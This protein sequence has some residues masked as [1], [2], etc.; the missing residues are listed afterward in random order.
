MSTKTTLH[1]ELEFQRELA[2]TDLD[3]VYT[4]KRETARRVLT[5]ARME[6]V[7]KIT[8]SE[9]ESVRDLARQVDRNVSVVSRDLAALYEADIIAYEENGR[10]K[11]P[12]LAHDN[13]IVSPILFDGEVI[14]E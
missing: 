11:R 2:K 9:I 1:A 4:I 13:I 12:I 10:A 8:T 14:E 7:E 6:L 5:E 3:D